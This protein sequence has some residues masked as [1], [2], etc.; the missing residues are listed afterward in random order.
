M[1]YPDAADVAATAARLRLPL[2]EAELAALTDRVGRELATSD[3]FM[4]RRLPQTRLPLSAPVRAPGEA[5]LDTDDPL[6]AWTWRCRIE[7]ESTP[8]DAPLTGVRVGLKDHTAVAGLPMT[9]ASDATA[10]VVADLDASVVTRVLDAGATVVGKLNMDNYSSASFGLGGYGDGRRVLNPHDHDRLAGGSSSGASAAVAADECDLAIGGDQAGSIRVPASW[11]G[12][13]GLKP[14]FGLVPHTGIVSASEPTIDHVGPLVRT[15]D[16][17]ARSMAALAGPDGVDVRQRSDDPRPTFTPGETLDPGTLRIG[18]L[19]EGFV[20][21]IDPEVDRLVRAAAAL[22]AAAG[23]TVVDVSVPEHD[24]IPEAY[25]ALT[26]E[27]AA[28]LWESNWLT[29]FTG[30]YLPERLSVAIG[31]MKDADAAQLPPNM[32]LN[33]LVAEYRRQQYKGGVYARAHNVRADLAASYDRALQEV[34]VLLM[35][36]APMVAPRFRDEPDPRARLESTLFGG[37]SGAQ[38]VGIGRNTLP[39]NYTGHPALSVPCGST[40]DTRMPVG[41][42]AV[43]ARWS[44]DLLV[45][46]ATTYEKLAEATG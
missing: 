1:P 40:E 38:L 20:D 9:W 39:F 32:K 25:S 2:T 29:P 30:G 31:R 33:Y 7:V 17:L 4:A 24:V 23:A 13:Y 11:C 18:L 37:E 22:F 19:V 8:E 27:G 5:P 15:A 26:V 12:I 14:T 45:R 21:P 6:G 34:D 42:Q 41:F 3:R 10:H 44:D 43:S 35:P 16:L 36:T 46:L 28:L